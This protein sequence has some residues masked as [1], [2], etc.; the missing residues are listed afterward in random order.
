MKEEE[1]LREIVSVL[2]N[3]VIERATA[4]VGQG[5]AFENAGR[6]EDAL[7][8]YAESLSWSDDDFVRR[9]MAAVERLIHERSEAV[10]RERLLARGLWSEGKVLEEEGR[11]YEALGKYRESLKAYGE[12][13]L[14]VRAD[15]LEAKLKERTRALVVEGIA[16]QR[17]AKFQ[18]ALDTFR[19]SLRYYPYREVEAHIGKLEEFLMK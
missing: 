5:D 13:E 4:L 9:R 18:E 7:A 6:L 1:D 14:R 3:L 16:L 17:D 2:E 11:L 8:A 15:T 12:E 19:E 10:S